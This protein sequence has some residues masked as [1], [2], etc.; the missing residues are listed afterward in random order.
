MKTYISDGD[1]STHG[2]LVSEFKFV[3]QSSIE[4]L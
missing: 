4:T 1:Y 2:N 3:L